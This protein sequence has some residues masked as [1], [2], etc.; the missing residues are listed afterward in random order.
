MLFRG[1]KKSMKQYSVDVKVNR[2]NDQLRGELKRRKITQ[3]DAAYR[4]GLEQQ[5]LSNRLSGKTP[6]TLREIVMICEVLEI[7]LGDFD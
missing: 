5:T 6:W 7:K 1:L 3:A 4:I 2:I